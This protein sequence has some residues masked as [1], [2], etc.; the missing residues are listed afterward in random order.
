MSPQFHQITI[1]K[2]FFACCFVFWASIGFSGKASASCGDYLRHHAGKLTQKYSWDI[3]R[4]GQPGESPTPYT[5]CKNGNCGEA[6]PALPLDSVRIAKFDANHFN[7]QFYLAL[8]MTD[9][10]VSLDDESPLQPTL[11]Q[12]DPPPRT[13]AL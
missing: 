7:P 8:G 4:G 13:L 1:S 3:A 12:T 2:A 11:D 5:G 10:L 6:P 9:K